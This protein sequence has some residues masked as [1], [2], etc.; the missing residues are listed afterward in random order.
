MNYDFLVLTRHY[1]N[2]KKRSQLREESIT[3]SLLG[4]EVVS[5][6][7][8]APVAAASEGEEDDPA[9]HVE[10]VDELAIRVLVQWLLHAVV[11]LFHKLD[12]R[13]VVYEFKVILKLTRNEL[14]CVAE[15][16]VYSNKVP[17]DEAT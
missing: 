17:S 3:V 9:N 1:Q 6:D 12:P 11:T 7:E 4:A 8:R 2:Q 5:R 14:P 15:S 10:P 13:V 16:P